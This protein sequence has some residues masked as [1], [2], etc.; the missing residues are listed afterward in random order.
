[1]FTTEK[2]V[3]ILKKAKTGRTAPELAERSGSSLGTT[4]R[5]ITRLMERGQ[6]EYSEYYKKCSKTGKELTSYVIM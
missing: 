5:A 6:L 4:R 2:I 1:M 3:K